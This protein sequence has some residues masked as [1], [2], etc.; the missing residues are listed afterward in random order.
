MILATLGFLYLII[1][2]CIC[3]GM[4][5]PKSKVGSGRICHKESRKQLCQKGFVQ[6]HKEFKLLG[7]LFVYLFNYTK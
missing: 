5:E 7:F 6:D 3:I 1:Y 4:L 2:A